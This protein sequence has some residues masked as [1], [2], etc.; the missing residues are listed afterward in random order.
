MPKQTSQ[1]SILRKW[2]K[3]TDKTAA[4]LAREMGYSYVHVY[5]VV[6][7]MVPI[8]AEFVGHLLVVYGEGGPAE[9]IAAVMRAERMKACNGHKK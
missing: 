5:Q 7:G 3:S 8:T 6:K 2:M 4:I 1:I 9:T